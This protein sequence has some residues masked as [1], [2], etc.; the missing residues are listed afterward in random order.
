M[1]TRLNTRLS[2]SFIV[3][4]LL[5]SLLSS[6]DIGSIAQKDKV[7]VQLSWFHSAEFIGFYVAD[8]LGYY[9]A[10]NLVVT[11]VPG[12]PDIDPVASVVKGASQFGI[13]SGDSIIRSQLA[14]QNLVAVSSI[15]RKSPLLVMSLANSGITTP[16]DLVGKTVGV[17]SQAMDSTW[18]IQFIAML[19]KVGVDQA[20]IKFVP[21]QEFHGAADL[22]TG[23][24]DATSG[25]FLTNELVQAKMDGE[26]ITPIYYRDY[27]VDFYNNLIFTNAQLVADKPDLV[28][29]FIQATLR[30]YQYAI[31]NPK[32]AAS[33]TLKYDKNLDVA[34]QQAT[35]EAQI[36]LMDTGDAPLGWM[37]ADVW[38]NTQTIL[39]DQG[40]IKSSVDLA[41]VYTNAFIK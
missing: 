40:Y 18:D 2:A 35:L 1:K 36:P 33:I 16:N 26:N 27:G 19:K 22:H 14:G 24:M 30:G 9:T 23:R 17:V 8:Q 12:G 29:R 28:K 4:I 32:E 37:D 13:T 11:L 20:K 31:E 25:T 7:S 34:F 10:E 38:A 39:L 3:L 5:A 15:Y 6:C 21:N 41:K